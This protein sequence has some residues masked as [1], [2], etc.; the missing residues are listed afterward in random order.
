[1]YDKKK[2]PM[3]EAFYVKTCLQK[4]IICMFFSTCRSHNLYFYTVVHSQ[5]LRKNM[6]T[7]L[8]VGMFSAKLP[9]MAISCKKE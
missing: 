2:L 7:V 1:M 9:H 8:F 4:I 5:I 3:K 6:P